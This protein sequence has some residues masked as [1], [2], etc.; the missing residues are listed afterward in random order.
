MTISPDEIT[1]QKEAIV[2]SDIVL[3]QLET[4]YEA[5]QQTIRLAQKNDIP[6]IINPAPYN[7]M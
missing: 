4:N 6:V 2:H 7:D 5:L 3:V 1:I